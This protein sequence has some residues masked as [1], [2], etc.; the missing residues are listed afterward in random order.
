VEKMTQINRMEVE[1]RRGYLQY[2]LSKVERA[3]L[4]LQSERADIQ[5]RMAHL[6]ALQKQTDMHA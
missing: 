5:H 4:K 3:M 2:A 6:N 1:R